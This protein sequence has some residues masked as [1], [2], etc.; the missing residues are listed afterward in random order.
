M[1]VGGWTLVAA[2]RSAVPAKIA[3]LDIRTQVSITARRLSSMPT[4]RDQSALVEL[5]VRVWVTDLRV[6]GRFG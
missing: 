3:L 2:I 6:C 5:F 4:M 1:G